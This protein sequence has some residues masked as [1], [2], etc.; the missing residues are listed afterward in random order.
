VLLFAGVNDGNLEEG[1]FRC[2]AKRLESGRAARPSGTRTEL[3]NI[4]SFPLRAQGHRVTR[5]SVRS[6]GSSGGGRVV[7][8]TRTWSERWQDAEHAQQGR[9]ARLPLLPDPTCRRCASS[10]ERRARRASVPE[11]PAAARALR[12]RARADRVRRRRADRASAD[13]QLLRGGH[14]GADAK[15]RSAREVAGKRVANF[16][17]IR[18]AAL[19]RPPAA[20][21]QLP[22]DAERWPGCSRWCR[23]HI[24][25]KMAKDVFEAM[26]ESGKDAESVVREQGLVQVSDAVAIERVVQ[27]VLGQN[28]KQVAQ[29]K[30]GNEK[31]LGF[32]VGQV[33][34]AMKGAGNPALVND[35]LKKA[36]SR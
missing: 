15:A 29:Y 28:A 9:G 14:G 34:K 25:G 26:R 19:R 23:R 36:L 8:E 21:A 24:S 1:P 20:R 11:L 16:V 31:L 13:R 2:D 12:A 18:G 22:G 3:K 27:E 35:V 33:M 30:A 4:N 7:Q 17:Q 5:S 6:P 32:F 10:A